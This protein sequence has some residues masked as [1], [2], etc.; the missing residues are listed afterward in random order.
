MIKELQDI[1][2]DTD[3]LRE[4][5]YKLHTLGTITKITKIS[6]EKIFIERFWDNNIPKFTG[7]YIE[8]LEELINEPIGTEI[9]IDGYET[10]NRNNKYSE[11]WRDGESIWY[12]E[13]GTVKMKIIWKNNQPIELTKMKRHSTEVEDKGELT[14]TPPVYKKEFV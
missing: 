1:L 9:R 8:M 2:N 3:F 10:G 11:G 7:Y 12:E 6:E 14:V 13:D 4:L 5:K